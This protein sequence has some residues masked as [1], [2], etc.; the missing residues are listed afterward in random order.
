MTSVI[1]GIMGRKPQFLFYG[2]FFFF[3]HYITA[4]ILLTSF[5]P[6]FFSKSDGT[7]NSPKRHHLT[8]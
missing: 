3:M 1:F 7:W 8:G 6:G 4:L 2:L 5:I